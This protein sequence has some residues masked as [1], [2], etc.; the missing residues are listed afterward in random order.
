MKT[1]TALLFISL[2]LFSSFSGT[3]VLEIKGH[4]NHNEKSIEKVMVVLYQNNKAVNKLF[5][6]KNGKFQFVLFSNINYTIE[7]SKN[8][9]INEKIQISTKN[10]K[11]NRGKYFYEFK[12]DLTKRSKFKGVDI[13]SLDFPTALIEYN[14]SKGEYEHNKKY[15]KYVKSE[16]KKLKETAAKL[17]N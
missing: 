7:V 14:P 9:F 5:T 16:F 1:L 3:N 8:S 13:S 12:I 4:V 2:F 17:K 6:K 10:N 11:A 15:A